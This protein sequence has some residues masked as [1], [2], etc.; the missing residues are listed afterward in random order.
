MGSYIKSFGKSFCGGNNLHGYPIAPKNDTMYNLFQSS[1]L[2]Y[3]AYQEQ[4]FQSEKIHADITSQS[5]MSDAI[6]QETAANVQ[7][8]K[9]T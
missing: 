5:T 2:Q 3:P 1:H 4:Y 8:D 9:A 7:L 6:K